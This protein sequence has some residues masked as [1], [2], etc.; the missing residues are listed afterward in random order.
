MKYFTIIFLSLALGFSSKKE[1]K[2][3]NLNKNLVTIDIIS[4]LS[5]KQTIDLSTLI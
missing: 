1:K 2:L 4:S 3:N 5:D